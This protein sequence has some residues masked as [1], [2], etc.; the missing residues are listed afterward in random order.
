MQKGRSQRVGSIRGRA[1]NDRSQEM[2]KSQLRRLYVLPWLG[3]GLWCLYWPIYNQDQQAE[4]LRALNL[5]VFKSCLDS[6]ADHEHC[7]KAKE[8]AEKELEESEVSPYGEWK[9]AIPF[10]AGLILI[11]PLIVYGLLFRAVPWLVRWAWE[12]NEPQKVGS[13]R[14]P[15]P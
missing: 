3:W 2:I 7:W 10:L 8:K 13:E 14:R 5:Q 9:I 1:R 12:W 6:D 11:L 15:H 4:K